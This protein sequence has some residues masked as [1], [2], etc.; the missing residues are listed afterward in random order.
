MA[1]QRVD[2]TIWGDMLL[3]FFFY[4]YYT[5]NVV[6]EEY[7]N[8]YQPP[9]PAIRVS[10][11]PSSFRERYNRVIRPLKEEKDVQADLVLKFICDV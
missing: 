1:V 11:A 3:V 8:A 2:L 5:Y 9:E 10:L 4:A 6:N 7:T